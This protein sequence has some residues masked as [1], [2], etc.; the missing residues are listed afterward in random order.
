MGLLSCIRLQLSSEVDRLKEFEE[1]AQSAPL[2]ASV[3]P[4]VINELQAE[5]SPTTIDRQNL[6][7][8]AVD[9]ASIH[10]F[11]VLSLWLP[12]QMALDPATGDIFFIFSSLLR[13]VLLPF[14]IALS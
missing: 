4:G 13:F 5:M 14:S 3:S 11:S 7:T 9:S 1:A 12:E 6:N 8:E 2:V 10:A